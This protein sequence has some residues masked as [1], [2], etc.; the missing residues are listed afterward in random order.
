MPQKNLVPQQTI[1]TYTPT[2]QMRTVCMYCDR[3]R[4]VLGHWRHAVHAPGQLISHGVC[5]SCYREALKEL[6]VQ[7]GPEIGKTA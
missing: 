1:P 7:L 4:M 6:M 5:P 2:S 3:Q